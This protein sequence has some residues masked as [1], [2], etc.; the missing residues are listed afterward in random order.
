MVWPVTPFARS[1]ADSSRVLLLG[2]LAVIF[3][4]LPR[5]TKDVDVWLDP[6]A[7]PEEWTA[8]VAR[9][10]ERFPGSYLWDLS[11]RERIDLDELPSCIVDVGVIRIGGIDGDL[12]IFRRPNNL[13]EEDFDAAWAESLP[14]AEEGVRV[15]DAPILIATK[16]DTGR[17]M[18]FDDIMFLE[19]KIRDEYSPILAGCGPEDARRMFARYVDH[20]TCRAA[21]T[22]PHEEVRAL[23]IETLREMAAG[24]NP[25]A[26]EMLAELDERDVAG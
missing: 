4:G 22:N 2:G 17:K 19:G 25:F 20:E 21:L 6:G 1:L 23:A 14:M 5:L 9:S 3:H 10:L 7:A 16:S 8:D 18:D 24:Q 13:K 12:D 26:R 11:R 15:L